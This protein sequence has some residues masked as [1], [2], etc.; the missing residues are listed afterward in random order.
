M[1]LSIKVKQ[2]Y[3]GEK[4][5]HS[6]HTPLVGIMNLVSMQPKTVLLPEK[7]MCKMGIRIV[8]TSK[9]IIKTK[10]TSIK[11]SSKFLVQG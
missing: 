2:K 3:T 4:N 10:M 8:A 11:C 9:D 1:N 7:P 6:D 5:F